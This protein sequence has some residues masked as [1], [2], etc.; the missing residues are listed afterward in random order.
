MHGS[1]DAVS[2]GAPFSLSTRGPLLSENSVL[3][4][5][6]HLKYLAYHLAPTANLREDLISVALRAIHYAHVTYEPG[7]GASLETYMVRCAQRAMLDFLR[8]EQRQT[9]RWDSGDAPRNADTDETLFDGLAA[10]DAESDPERMFLLQQVKYAVEELPE[11][12]RECIQQRYYEGRENAEIAD[13]LGISRPRVTQLIQAGLR[14]LRARLAFHTLT[15]ATAT[16]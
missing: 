10:Q 15:P 9:G 11:R 1:T 6:R 14:L 7:R 12:Q 4:I 3:T 13:N 5:D 2:H 8:T 16:H